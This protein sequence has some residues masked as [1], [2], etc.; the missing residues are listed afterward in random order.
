VAE[1]IDA[2]TAALDKQK[3]KKIVLPEG[4]TTSAE[5]G[6]FSDQ[7][8]KLRPGPA[9]GAT[10]LTV[11]PRTLN[12]GATPVSS[13]SVDALRTVT[14]Q[15]VVA[16]AT[17]A[18]DEAKKAVK[19]API[20]AEFKK[21]V[22]DQLGAVAE[23][24]VAREIEL[25]R[26]GNPYKHAIR[27]AP[28]SFLRGQPDSGP[29]TK[30]F[31]LT[32]RAGMLEHDFGPDYERE[33]AEGMARNAELDAQAVD[34]VSQALGR[35]RYQMQQQEGHYQQMAGLLG[36]VN[37]ALGGLA[38]T[39]LSMRQ[40]LQTGDSFGAAIAGAGILLDA[41]MAF[42]DASLQ[43]AHDFKRAQEELRLTQQA[44]FDVAARVFPTEVRQ[45]REGMTGF[46]SAAYERSAKMGSLR[47]ESFTGFL[48]GLAVLP[49]TGGMLEEVTK[50]RGGYS[51][52]YEEYLKELFQTDDLE[53]YIRA[54]IDAFGPNANFL[55]IASRA[56][57]DMGVVVD[58][59]GRSAKKAVDGIGELA[60]IMA[61]EKFQGDI[62]GARTQLSRSFAS[63]GGDVFEQRRA[64]G[65][66]E[67]VLRGIQ[68]SATLARSR[69]GQTAPG[70]AK[71]AGDTTTGGGISF[72]Q[73]ASPSSW[74]STL[75]LPGPSTRI[76]VPYS[77]AIDFQ[78]LVI[79]D[80]DQL[81]NF[82]VPPPLAPITVNAG[83]PRDL[84]RL[85][86][87][88][89]D[90]WSDILNFPALPAPVA[91]ITINAGGPRDLVRLTKATID[92][93]SD[94]LN[95]PSLPA[96]LQP[97]EIG[98]E[99]RSGVGLTHDRDMI[100]IRPLTI[101]DWSDLLNFASLP[102]RLQPIMVGV[103][104]RGSVGREHDRDLIR[105]RP[106]A[107]DDWSDILTFP[108]LPAPL[109]PITV[110]T[111]GDRDLIRLTPYA[112]TSWGQLFAFGG[113]VT[114]GA[115]P[116]VARIALRG[117]DI[118]TIAKS[119]LDINSILGVTGKINV[120]LADYINFDGGGLREKLFRAV[121]Q[122]IADRQIRMRAN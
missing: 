62:V 64:L 78:K 57:E 95:F 102:P 45:A 89:I 46:V 75:R 99:G 105:I 6:F 3:V 101:D 28:S 10:T 13:V 77:D 60:A 69:A 20:T 114:T 79:S 91:P 5:R 14:E 58:D 87:A 37:P 80:W 47:A 31:E 43:A 111:G 19:A 44:A 52:A 27:G 115:P 85:A 108:S 54:L 63:A 40:S 90:D 82:S 92:D 116:T 36:K 119:S 110:N 120:A 51:D 25:L 1:G 2:I 24:M 41:I 18:A 98:V 81:I 22:T 94:I 48:K 56:L 8:R 4:Y 121:E 55:D 16:G 97:I 117:A 103:E 76:V 61:S 59:L 72:D 107:I 96:R 9:A 67:E 15:I 12:L 66:F 21:M 83:G 113:D 17:K 106:L 30:E 11:A 32:K 53:A 65:V 112:V 35:H 39:I 70:A 100:R 38:S 84:V 68:A 74:E 109:Q 71:A 122:G 73:P 50:S 104:G 86:K 42:G 33:R 49:T 34:Q 88:T 26:A 7:P 29:M 118:L 93:W 23:A